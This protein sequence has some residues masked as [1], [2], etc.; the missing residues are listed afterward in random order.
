[1]RGMLRS[2]I[3]KVA[4]ACALAI[5]TIPALGAATAEAASPGTGLPLLC[6]GAGQIFV[7]NT[8]PAQ[9]AVQGGGS[10]P[11]ITFGPTQIVSV[12]G[13]GTSDSLGLCSNQLLVTNLDIAIT[14][15]FTNVVTGQQIVQHQHWA[16]PISFFPVVTPFLVSSDSGDFGGGLIISHIFLH[17]GNDGGSPSMDFGWLQ[18]T[19]PS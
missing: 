1:M 17:C 13:T 5:G 8:S 14:V 7:Q 9:W 16:S 18:T 12:V 10:C 19:Q 2:S 3:V 4:L 11:L 6:T 15:T